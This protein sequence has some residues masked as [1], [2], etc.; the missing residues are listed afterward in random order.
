MQRLS[1]ILLMVLAFPV[2]AQ[3]YPGKAIKIIVP[4]PAGGNA[5]NFARTI[6]QKLNESY[7]QMLIIDNRPGATGTIGAALAAKSPPDGY[8][9]IE[10]ISSSYIAGFLN[11]DV[12]YDPAKAFAPIIN[13]AKLPFALV[14]AASQP[15]KSVA[16]LIALAR[17]RPDEVTYSTAGSASAGHL[18][19]QLFNSITGI[20]TVHVPYKGSAQSM[21]ALAQGEAL[22]GFVNLLDPQPFLKAR[23]IRAL[24]VT[25]ANRSPTMPDVPTMSEA[26]LPDFAEVY[27]WLG[28]FAPAGAPKQIV[29]KLNA[30]IARILATPKM[31]E[32]LL[33]DLGGEFAPNTPSQFNEFL[34]AD[35]A[36]WMKVIKETGVQLD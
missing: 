30:D 12:S 19:T 18:V 32:W 22:F 33:H 16:D 29:D 11:R 4:Y 3:N 20:R 23:K 10:H 13:C 36:R 14:A 8:T 17:R 35:T 34:V 6:A 24:A 26:G 5:D 1:S 15:A 9:L 25:G 21:M 28:M 2:A 7:G 27:M 31:K